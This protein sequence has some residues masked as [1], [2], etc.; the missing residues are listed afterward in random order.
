MKRRLAK[1]IKGAE[2]LTSLSTTSLLLLSICCVTPAF[3]QSSLPRDGQAISLLGRVADALGGQRWDPSLALRETFTI[4]QWKGQAASG[5]ITIRSSHGQVR[6]DADVST[7][8]F[9]LFFD[10]QGFGQWRGKDGVVKSM[11]PVDGAVSKSISLY[12]PVILRA[13]ADPNFGIELLP[14]S[15][16]GTSK[17][18]ITPSLPS[19]ADPDGSLA[20]MS[21]FVLVIDMN[22]LQITRMEDVARSYSQP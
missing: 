14:D 12:L 13:L 6:V 22:S 17:V 5:T 19:Q 10:G 16:S 9:A 15:E 21:R 1:L 3:A 8:S 20:A 2:F 7:D 18:R 4:D 11:S